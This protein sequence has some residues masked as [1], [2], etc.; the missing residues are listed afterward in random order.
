[1]KTGKVL[2]G[3]GL[4]TLVGMVGYAMSR[5]EGGERL[6][7]VT[8]KGKP[9]TL[10]GRAVK[11]GDAAP[12]FHAVA[13]DLSVYHFVPGGGKVWIVSAVPSL[14][15]PV[16]STET[17]RFNQEAAGLGQGIG[18]L[19]VSMDLPFA[20]KRWCAAEGVQNVQTVS[21]FRD[22]EFARAYGVL[23][24]ENGLLSRS[25]FVVDKTGRVT[26]VQLVPEISHEPDYSAALE[27]AKK[28]LS[29]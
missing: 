13:N 7:L 10:V 23:M 6:G 11:V 5:T 18:I 28:A 26:Y 16:C 9:I 21:D 1:M 14:D 2:A 25:V 3:L 24:K 15:T 12:E 19:T 22:R 29:E 20:Q 8:M 4:G 27:A 17:R